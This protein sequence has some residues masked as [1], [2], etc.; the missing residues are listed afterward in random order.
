[1]HGP[2]PVHADPE[3]AGRREVSSQG[4]PALKRS[5]L[6]SEF[7]FKGSGSAWRANLGKNRRKVEPA[8]TL[9]SQTIYPP[10][11]ATI[12]CVFDS[13]RPLPRANFVVKDGSK[14]RVMVF[15]VIPDP[16]SCTRISICT[17]CWLPISWTA[18]TMGSG[19]WPYLAKALPVQRH[20]MPYLGVAAAILVRDT[21]HPAKSPM[22]SGT[23][24]IS[25]LSEDSYSWRL[26][27][28]RPRFSILCRAGVVG[29]IRSRRERIC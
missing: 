11:L 10:A 13:P 1:M 21:D 14:I 23:R 18:L 5:R 3:P 24:R 9:L 20:P 17:P 2:G 26:A 8:P 4:Q 6:Y 12:A 29:L 15:P 25:S 28:A 19:F 27:E 16:V 22:D 7:E